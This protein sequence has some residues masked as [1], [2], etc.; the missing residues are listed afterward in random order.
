MTNNNGDHLYSFFPHI[1]AQSAMIG[2]LIITMK[3][4]ESHPYLI[5]Y[6]LPRNN[7]NNVNNNN[8]HRK[9][10]WFQVLKLAWVSGENLC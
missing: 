6:Q 7:D 4:K 8:T 1:H 10:V 2:L 3:D 9:T 5:L